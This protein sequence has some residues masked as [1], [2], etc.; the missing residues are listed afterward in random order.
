FEETEIQDL[1][2]LGSA[3][4]SQDRNLEAEIVFK[5]GLRRLKNGDSHGFA[6]SQ[7]I[8]GLSMVYM[9]L[10]DYEQH[11]RLKEEAL[12]VRLSALPE[13]R[14]QQAIKSEQAK[15]SMLMRLTVPN[16]LDPK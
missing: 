7:M 3:C 13:H 4:S 9:A 6:K 11:H 12:Q 1:L 2:E 10:K 15:D 14:R 5:H 16:N 8:S